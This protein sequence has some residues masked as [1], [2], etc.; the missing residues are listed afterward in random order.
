MFERRSDD[1]NLFNGTFVL[2]FIT[3]VGV[4]VLVN[5]VSYYIE[6]QRY[7]ENPIQF[8]FAFGLPFKWQPSTS[9]LNFVFVV[10][11]AFACG[12]LARYFFRTGAKQS[13]GREDE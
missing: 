4:F 3:S 10:I 8:G 12:L 2:G 5:M 13:V 1:G 7:E 6:W 9:F 11:F